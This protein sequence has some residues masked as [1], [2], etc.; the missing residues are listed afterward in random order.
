M[1]FCDDEE[2]MLMKI[3][4]NKTEESNM[5]KLGKC[6]TRTKDGVMGRPVREA[7]RMIDAIES[8]NHYFLEKFH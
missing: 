8:E 6:C 2:R 5:V 7:V 3:V 1:N 4:R